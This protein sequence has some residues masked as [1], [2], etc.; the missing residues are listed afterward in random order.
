MKYYILLRITHIFSN[1]K[2]F[3]K[4]ETGKILKQEQNVSKQ[5]NK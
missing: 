3:V 5:T 4:K 2:N 1:K